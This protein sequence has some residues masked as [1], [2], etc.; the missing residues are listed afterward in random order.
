[1]SRVSL[2]LSNGKELNKFSSYTIKTDMHQLATSFVFCS[3]IEGN[4]FDNDLIDEI[5]ADPDCEI[6]VD[7]T[8]I[9]VGRI[10]QIDRG[11]DR[12]QGSWVNITGEDLLGC[13]IKS[14]FRRETSI[15]NLSIKEAF[16]YVFEPWGLKV[17]NTN[18]LNRK[19]ITERRQFRVG[20]ETA[21]INYGQNQQIQIP[22]HKLTTWT[23][24]EKDDRQ[25]I[26]QPEQ[27]IG[28][29]VADVT[30]KYG[31]L[32]WL[33][34]EGEIVLCKPNYEQTEIPSII[35]GATNGEGAVRRAEESYRPIDTSTEIELC[36]RL[37]RKNSVK[38]TKS[39]YNQE[40][41]DAGWEK[42]TLEV[43]DELKDANKAEEKLLRIKHDELLNEWS[44]NCTINGHSATNFLICTDLVVH[45]VH[46]AIGLDEN[47]YCINR[48]FKKDKQSGTTCDLQFVKCGLI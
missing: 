39:T 13:A 34:S 16:E 35:V 18:D 3:Q 1:M 2:K 19:L 45:C 26:P 21:L 46:P 23:V 7:G 33:S 48:T 12:E 9:L 10:G 22:I 40:L 11:Q 8:K 38:F 15:T 6:Y 37:G 32:C 44:W 25:L 4:N 27:N 42:Y 30:K 5:K 47:L 36:G 41:I 20:T 29:W 28:T 24:T 17:V 14:S 43:D 31:Y